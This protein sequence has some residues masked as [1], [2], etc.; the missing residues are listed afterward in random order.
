LKNAFGEYPVIKSIG[1]DGRTLD[2]TTSYLKDRD[3]ADSMVQTKLFEG[4]KKVLPANMTFAQFKTTIEKSTTVL[5]SISDDL[6]E[7]RC[8]SYHLCHNS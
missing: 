2:I 8:Q 5:P 7:R 1:T 6:K 4:V 3:N